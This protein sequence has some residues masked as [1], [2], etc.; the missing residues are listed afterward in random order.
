MRDFTRQGWE[1]AAADIVGL[2][3]LYDS[4]VVIDGVTFY[5]TPYFS[6]IG[7]G[8]EALYFHDRI[9]DFHQCSLDWDV[10]RH[11]QAHYMSIMQLEDALAGGLDIDVMI[12]HWPI[13]MEA[14][15]QRYKGSPTTRYYINDEPD[16]V[17]RVNAKY[18]I[19]GHTHQCFAY[20]SGGTRCVG[21]P[22]GYP[23][24]RPNPLFDPQY[25]LEV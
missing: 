6:D 13:T 8:E 23:F 14:E 20:E 16:M 17:E 4:H 18:W 19:A 22:A 12:T 24:E 21:N 5:G 25:T 15:D 10:Y 3:F 7:H 11:T 1:K 9:N 2:H